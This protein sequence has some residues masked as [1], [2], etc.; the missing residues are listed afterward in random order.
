M[1]KTMIDKCQAIAQMAAEDNLERVNRESAPVTPRNSFYAKYIKRIIDLVVVIPVFLLLLPVNLV[2]G[3]ITYFDVGRPIFFK[4]LRTGKEVSLT[5]PGK[6][7][8]FFD[9]ET[10]LNLIY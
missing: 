4:Q 6:V 3:I 7:M 8:Y 10:E 5:F 1:C 9:P 2:I